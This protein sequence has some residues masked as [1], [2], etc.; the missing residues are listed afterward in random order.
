M[1][2]INV[3]PIAATLAVLARCHAEPPHAEHSR[4]DWPGRVLCAV[5]LGGIIF[6]LIEA[7][8]HG[9]S[10]PAITLPLAAGAGAFVG[11]PDLRARRGATRCST[12]RCSRRRNFAVGNAATAAIYAGLTAFTFLLTVFLQQVAGYRATA[13]GLALLPV[14]AL[15][16]A[17][18]PSPAVWPASTGRAGS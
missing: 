1:F 3:A 9:W 18:S 11:V 8:A 2:A 16:F 7:P 15:M 14:T 13:A 10:R 17:L 12:S 4:V 6:A 5:G